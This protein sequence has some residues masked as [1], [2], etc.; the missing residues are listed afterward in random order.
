M[1]CRL[2][3]QLFIRCLSFSLNIDSLNYWLQNVC[4]R[5]NKNIA[6]VA[7]ANKNARIMWAIL[8]KKTNYQMDDVAA[9]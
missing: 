6:A 3:R 2:K 4:D 1:F 7:L 8:T 9:A 5:R